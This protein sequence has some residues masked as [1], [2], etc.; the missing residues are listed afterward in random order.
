MNL[1]GK[2]R[3]LTLFSNKIKSTKHFEMSKK[4]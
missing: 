3:V 1:K 4:F 2:T